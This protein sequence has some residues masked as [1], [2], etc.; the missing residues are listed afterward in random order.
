MVTEWHAPVATFTREED[1]SFIC[2]ERSRF[3]KITCQHNQSRRGYADGTG[4]NRS[5][6]R[7]RDAAG[8]R[9][10]RN[11]ARVARKFMFNGW[12]PKKR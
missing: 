10:S 2:C 4:I 1:A 9:E 8:G 7:M 11:L 3:R 6:A 5:L 12:W